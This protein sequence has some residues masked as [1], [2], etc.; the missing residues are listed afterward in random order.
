MRLALY[1]SIH[2][3][4]NQLRK[5]FRTWL[6][7]IVLSLL[8]G[9]GLIG[10]GAARF[11]SEAQ[12]A[13]NP[14][15]S[16]LPADFMEFFDASGLT[17]ADAAELGAGLVILSVLT[18]QIIGAE[19]SVS[20]L[21]LPADVNILFA[22][23]RSPQE[24]LSFRLFTTL[25]TAAVASLYLFFQ[26]PSLVTKFGLTPLAAASFILSWIMTLAFSIQLKILTFE[27]ASRHPFLK[28][29]LRIL[30]MSFLAL[31]FFSFYYSYHVSEERVLLLSAHR[32]F[33]APWTRWIPIW[34]W[35]KGIIAFSLHQETGK[36]VLLAG[37]SIALLALFTVLIQ[38]MPVDYYEEAVIRCEEL[39]LFL[40]NVNSETAGL[41]VMRGRRK[42]E[43]LERDGFRY[44]KGASVFFHKT[45]YNRLRFARFG[46]FTKTM[47]TYLFTG[48]A[49]GLFVRM[50]MDRPSVYPP[51]FLIAVM[52][53]F[54]TITSPLSEDV[55]RDSFVMIPENTWAKLF[56]SLLGGTLNSALDAAIPLM[57]GAAAA[58]VF[59]PRGL[60][61]LPLVVSVDF[62]ATAV[63]TF[64]ETV[65]PT[66]IDR[67]FRQV[68]QI[69]FLYF[70]MIP[71]EMIIAFGFISNHPAAG[72]LLAVLVN[73]LA[74]TLF[75]A[76]AGVWLDP[77]PGKAVKDPGWKVSLSEALSCYS[78]IGAALC[79]M[80]LSVTALQYLMTAVLEILQSKHEVINSLSVT[81][82]VY[83]A[84]IPVF[85]FCTR[86][87][88]TERKEESSLSAFSLVCA[89]SCCLFLMY[90]GNAVGLFLNGFFRSVFAF[91]PSLPPVGGTLPL[92]IPTGMLSAALLAPFME[93]F[94]FR[95]CVI[96]RLRPYG[97]RTAWIV[98]ALGF[99][100]FHGNL[101]QAVYAFLLGL[102]F[103]YIYLKTG[104]LRYTIALHA[105]VNFMGS[106]LLPILLRLAGASLPQNVPLY[107]LKLM[108]V[109]FKPGF[110]A[111][112]I[113]IA[114]V[115]TAALFGAAVTA[116]AVRNNDL[117]PDTVPFSSVVRTPGLCAF[118]LLMTGVIL[119]SL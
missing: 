89:F 24:V 79:A 69:L 95:R 84:G 26:M 39:A 77:C 75:S 30:V 10:L 13:Q 50:F 46:I 110:L 52:A 112:L 44:G 115:I 5:L 58:G 36:A 43:G 102:V 94:V 32:F 103:G 73:L 31:L 42:E 80:Y 37:L 28:K 54:R 97:Q 105:G 66:S 23:D 8:L 72:I 93:E 71:D 111:L 78:Q 14:E 29:N 116:W 61:F 92:S 63:G 76:L 83:A 21:F 48:I 22:S 87:M 62:F 12:S 35:L 86:H 47:I 108:D 49:G 113:Y 34:G 59:F 65:I 38:I 7:L 85:L 98:S 51:V 64:V 106:I 104:K 18:M 11:S 68:I 118:I 107:D 82:P 27:I 67:T 90:A 57:A 6:F 40:E 100:L 15:S 33:N 70:G 56:F 88:R 41:L 99:S 109:I 119:L 74:G 45:M 3:T 16:V 55:R 114:L 25:G 60:L 96:D 53:F 4:W 117:P 101:P 1:Y 81:L 2:T 91:L 17:A 19:K 9:G 20:R